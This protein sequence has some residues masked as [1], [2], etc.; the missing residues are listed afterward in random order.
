M[1]NNSLLIIDNVKE[2]SEYIPNDIKPYLDIYKDLNQKLSEVQ[3]K[4]EKNF[5]RVTD[6]SRLKEAVKEGKIKIGKYSIVE[7]RNGRYYLVKY[8]DI[9]ANDFS[10]IRDLLE[11][12]VKVEKNPQFKEY[13][14]SLILAYTNNNF[15]EPYREWVSLPA[16]LKYDFVFFPTEPYLDKEFETMLSFES[17][18]KVAAPDTFFDSKNDYHNY[19][20]SIVKSLPTFSEIHENLD[21][22]K[23]N[24]RIDYTVFSGAATPKFAFIGQ[25]L[26]N[27][28]E[29]VKNWGSKINLYKTRIVEKLQDNYIPFANKYM[30]EPLSL[31]D[32]TEGITKLVLSHEIVE[33]LMKFEGDEER[34]GTQYLAVREMNSDLNGIRSYF[35]FLLKTNFSEKTFRNIIHF[36]VQDLLYSYKRYSKSKYRTQHWYGYV[37]TFNYLLKQ[38]SITLNKEGKIEIDLKRVLEDFFVLSEKTLNLLLEGTEEEAREFFKPYLGEEKLKEILKL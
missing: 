4:L 24:F 14:N 1:S 6:I 8:S 20:K 26:P 19:L 33:S 9:F 38:G 18:L 13:L 17:H 32:Y 22:S 37:Y 2:Y 3:E 29:F 5:Y 30:A 35:Y 12:L 11:K 21:T 7:E 28:R 15:I 23:I 34:L 27:E 10:K 16:D 36:H 25:N 31:E